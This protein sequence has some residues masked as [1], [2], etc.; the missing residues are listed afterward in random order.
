MAIGE[1]LIGRAGLRLG[2]SYLGA[3]TNAGGCDFP[4]SAFHVPGVNGAVFYYVINGVLAVCT[5]CLY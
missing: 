1:A 3:K 2:G 4:S 5:S